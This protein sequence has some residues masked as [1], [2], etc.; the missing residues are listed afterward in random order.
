MFCLYLNARKLRDYLSR[1]MKS[2]GY[3]ADSL[4]A[5][6]WEQLAKNM[7]PLIVDLLYAHKTGHIP[8]GSRLDN[9]NAAMSAV[10]DLLGMPNVIARSKPMRI[11]DKDG[12]VIEGTFMEAV[13]GYDFKNLP[14]E[15]ARIT[16][17]AIQNTDGKAF[18]DLANLQVLD[19]I[20]GNYDR[21][22]ANMFYQFDENGRLW[23][24]PPPWA[25]ATGRSGLRPGRNG[26][27][28]PP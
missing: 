18:R 24:P 1:G 9:R 8:Y 16:P 11:V 5:D 13:K 23:R 4:T 15:A 27:R 6:S 21:H 12:N 7:E 28:P 26:S 22:Y 14:P 19:Y 2:F 25:W 3:N 17:A 20:C 10:A